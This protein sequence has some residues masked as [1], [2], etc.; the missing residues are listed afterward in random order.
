[1]TNNDIKYGGTYYI[2]CPKC[3]SMVEYY[4][5]CECGYSK[6]QDELNRIS[7]I[8]KNKSEILLK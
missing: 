8:L 5:I 2:K 7:D 6:L 1:M 4:D 3:G